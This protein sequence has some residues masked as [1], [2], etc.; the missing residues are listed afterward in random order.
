MRA[1][2]T[3]VLFL[4]IIALTACGTTTVPRSASLPPTPTVTESAKLLEDLSQLRQKVTFPILVPTDVPEGLHGAVWS[5]NDRSPMIYI[6][7]VSDDGKAG[8]LIANG[9]R[10]TGLEGL[11]GKSQERDDSRQ[12]RGLLLGEPA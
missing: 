7:Y 8:L 4:S 11:P 9:P 10:G 3:V 5:S 1:K 2:L 6:R 12:H